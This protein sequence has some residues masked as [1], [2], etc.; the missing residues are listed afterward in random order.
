MSRE[1][2]MRIG[3]GPV[4]VG[5]AGRRRAEDDFG[6]RSR[7][8]RRHGDLDDGLA[9]G[10]VA[11]RDRRR[12]DP[13]QRAR[14]GARFRRPGASGRYRRRALTSR[15]K[16]SPSRPDARDPDRGVGGLQ[17]EVPPALGPGP[18]GR[19]AYRLAP[20]KRPVTVTALAD[21]LIGRERERPERT[22]RPAAAIRRRRAEDHE[23]LIAPRPLSV[24]GR[25]DDRLEVDV[26]EARVRSLQ[27]PDVPE[28]AA[29]L[30]V[31]GAMGESRQKTKTGFAVLASLISCPA[32]ST[33]PPDDAL[34]AMEEHRGGQQRLRRR[35]QRVRAL[36]R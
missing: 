36:A 2:W 17:H 35:R 1:N 32:G 21:V 34:F 7:R 3:A 9:S 23:D 18:W 11:S 24:R 20:R 15:S 6:R 28:L 33:S 30:A 8:R 4:G 14:R 25:V 5:F 31:R 13:G 26:R 22:A 19:S 16:S 27:P 29:H 12:F 10:A